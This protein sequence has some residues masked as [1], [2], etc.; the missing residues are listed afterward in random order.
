M[1]VMSMPNKIAGIYFVWCTATNKKYIGRAVD[2]HYRLA[3][4]LLQLKRGDHPKKEMQNDFNKHGEGAFIFQ[5]YLPVKNADDRCAIEYALIKRQHAY[6]RKGTSY[7]KLPPKGKNRKPWGSLCYPPRVIKG[8]R[9]H[10]TQKETNH[11]NTK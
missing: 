5:L 9:K 7:N 1:M 2:V 8:K 4:H 3:Y 11:A 6:D 10:S